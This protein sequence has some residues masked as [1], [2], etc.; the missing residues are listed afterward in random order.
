MINSNLFV[1]IWFIILF[2]N[3]YLW[4]FVAWR[5]AYLKNPK[6]FR[7]EYNELAE[8][9][10]Q[11][12]KEACGGR[13][14]RMNYTMGVLTVIVNDK[15]ILLNPIITGKGFIYFHEVDSITPMRGVLSKRIKITHHSPLVKS[16]VILFTAFSD[17]IKDKIFAESTSQ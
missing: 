8:S 6:L 3:V 5:F 13:I 11:Y 4:I 7:K 10:P 12:L 16:P 14:G 17:K 15:A 1:L 2:F 9:S